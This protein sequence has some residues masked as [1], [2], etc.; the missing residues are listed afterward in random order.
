MPNCGHIC[1]GV[2][3]FAMHELDHNPRAHARII[4]IMVVRSGAVAYACAVLLSG[5]VQCAPS[6]QHK[7]A[8][9]WTGSNGMITTLSDSGVFL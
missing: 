2:S 6:G 9:T 8:I 7:Y 4:R 3:A 5:K 1:N